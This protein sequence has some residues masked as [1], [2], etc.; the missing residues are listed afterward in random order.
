MT[1]GSTTSGS[2]ETLRDALG[3]G[4]SLASPDAVHVRDRPYIRHHHAD[5]GGHRTRSM[6]SRGGRARVCPG[7]R[8][9]RF[10][11]LGSNVA[12]R[13][14]PSARR[15]RCCASLGEESRVVRRRGPVLSRSAAAFPRE[16]TSRFYVAGR[17]PAVLSQGREVADGVHHRDVLV[18]QDDRRAAAQ[19][20]RACSIGRSPIGA[21]RDSWLYVA[22]Y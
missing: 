10:S 1:C 2:S 9:E 22:I 4:A 16:P 20:D 3:G 17:G 7:S 12:D 21:R 19:V 8:A 11:A 6:S 13:R 14:P 15:S 18:G 5:R